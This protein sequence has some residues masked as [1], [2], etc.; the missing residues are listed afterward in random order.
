M[1]AL[2]LH[3]F[4]IWD[5]RVHRAIRSSVCPRTERLNAP[6]AEA[7]IAGNLRNLTLLSL[8]WQ[9]GISTA[10]VCGAS[11]RQS[12]KRWQI[13]PNGPWTSSSSE[14]MLQRRGIHKDTRRA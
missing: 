1:E 8:P 6:R 3:A 9:Q 5:A 13:V 4:G 7:E 2:A 12:A 11:W 10:A 14:Q